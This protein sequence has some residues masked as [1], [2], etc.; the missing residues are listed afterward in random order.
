MVLAALLRVYVEVC[1]STHGAS[2]G[3]R[4]SDL[5]FLGFRLASSPTYADSLQDLQC[6]RWAAP[7]PG[8]SLPI[9]A[10]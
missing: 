2:S 4:G 5:Q 3:G 1:Y 6:S 9:L 7:R 10:T 8:R